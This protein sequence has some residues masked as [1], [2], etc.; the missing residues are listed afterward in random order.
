MAWMP[1]RGWLAQS[2]RRP[3][4]WLLAALFILIT[5]F[6]YAE[7]I[8]HPSFLA[9]LTENLGLTRY[10]VER[11][12]YLL[13]I[14][15]AAFMFGWR[16]G[17]VVSLAALACMLPRDILTSPSAEDALVEITT[18]TLHGRLL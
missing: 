9:N 8:E 11:I 16:G 7:Q 17:A 6:Q 4:T 10:T 13:P 3:G 2:I 5:F 12:L 14:I 1:S 15:W 18:R